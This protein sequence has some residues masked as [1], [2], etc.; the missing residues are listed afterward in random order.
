[1]NDGLRSSE[2]LAAAVVAGDRAAWAELYLL[3]TPRIYGFFLVRLRDDPI[4]ADDLTQETLIEVWKAL[5]LRAKPPRTF[6]PWIFKIAHN[7][8][9]GYLQA[10]KPEQTSGLTTE[11]L[12]PSD[13]AIGALRE[14]EMR[15]D[16][17]WFIDLL[18]DAIDSMPVRYRAVLRAHLATGATGADLA[19]SAGLS[20]RE[21]TKWH[22]EGR[23][24]FYNAVAVTVMARGKSGTPCR[25]F[26]AQLSA[27]G[28][29]GGPLGESLRESLTNHIKKCGPCQEHRQKLKKTLELTPVFLP[30]LVPASVYAA[31]AANTD[32]DQE[33]K[34]DDKRR[35]TP[36]PALV[37]LTK[38]DQKLTGPP[39]EN[40]PSALTRTV[41]AIADFLGKAVLFV[42]A[43]LLLREFAPEVVDE[44]QNNRNTAT[45]RLEIW[46]PAGGYSVSVVPPGRTCT[47]LPNCDIRLRPG[48]RVTLTARRGQWYNGPL[49]WMGCPA[50]TDAAYPCTFVPTGRTTI[51]LIEPGYQGVPWDWCRGK[52]QPGR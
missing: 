48:T 50:G 4:A 39:P 15:K 30:V 3:W 40:K 18:G 10:R 16:W 19:E 17:P 52:R 46:V 23:R 25:K 37:A 2:E 29:S 7:R 28:W 6:R 20:A 26:T 36:A 32:P 45:V 34:R 11:T 1:M 38:P 35:S 44:F 12:R 51:C 22:S 42:I 9:A 14:V 24:M 27:A 31:I 49:T 13:F 5:E 33:E 8:L 47:A 41:D 43:V 21:A